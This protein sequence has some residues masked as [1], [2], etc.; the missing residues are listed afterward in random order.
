MVRS[1]SEES[2]SDSRCGR[3]VD[4]ER[5]AR[6]GF[7]CHDRG[8]L[9][10][11]LRVVLAPVLLVSV[12]ASCQSAKFYSQA[13]RGQWEVLSKARP[14]AKVRVAPDTKPEL[15]KQLE[16]VE[17]MRVFARDE[18]KLPIDRQYRDYTDLGRRYVVW[19]VI[20]APEFSV[21]AKTWSY[22]FVGKLKY[23]GFF[24]EKAAR[25]EAT[26]LKA[27]G[28][29]VS[30]GG[31][32]VYST[33]G[34]FSDPV[35][36]TFI[37]E[38]EADLAETLF[39]ELTHAR[40]FVGGDT[41]FDE[42]YATASAQLAVRDWFLSRKDPRSLAEYERA[43]D[44]STRVLGLLKDTRRQLAALYAKSSTMKEEEMRRRKAMIL[45]S[46]KTRYA[47]MKR[48]GTTDGSHS[49]WVGGSLNNARLAALATY[50]DLVPAF[51]RLYHEEGGDWER[52]HR[53]VAAMK[54][55]SKE[56]RRKRLDAPRPPPRSRATPPEAIHLDANP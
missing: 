16:L 36:N 56:E 27:E 31:V 12:L 52:F 18:L 1:V 29:D 28:F 42:A 26:A 19:N 30:M 6:R 53:A 2:S 48:K 35:L 46:V 45:N 33:L 4:G 17:E 55:L 15:R 34:V 24:S 3:W 51:V 21:E 54:P 10:S 44:Q 14:I 32:R 38:E 20:A 39:H 37:N 47:E 7:L 50:H 49:G 11:G 23:R 43:H 9:H 22:P 40:L 5:C 13:L 25:A 41:D 8:M